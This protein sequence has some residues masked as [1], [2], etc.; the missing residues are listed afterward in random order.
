MTNIPPLLKNGTF[1]THSQKK[2]DIFNDFFIRQCSL[3]LN[4]SVLPNPFPIC[5]NHLENINA[6]SDNVLKII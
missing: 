2:T 5:N 1:V 6:D 4:D 3:N